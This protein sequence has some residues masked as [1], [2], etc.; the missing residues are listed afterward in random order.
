MVLLGLPG[1]GK[2]TAAQLAADLLEAPWC[3]L[4]ARVEEAAGKTVA[5][6]FDGQGEAEFRRLER[7]AMDRALAEPAQVI[8]AGGGWAAEPGN[9]ARAELQ[10]LLIYLSISP[11][12]AAQRL[13]SASDRPML[14]SGDLTAR[15]T[16]ILAAREKWYRLAAVEVAVGQASPEAAAAGI[17]AAARQYGGW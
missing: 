7:L 10:A 2:T 16:E 1:A 5:E 9:I 11:S 8:A 15:L 3:D 13:T 17:A 6:I 14:R 4:D 12:D